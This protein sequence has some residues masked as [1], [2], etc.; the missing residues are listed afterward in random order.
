[1]DPSAGAAQDRPSLAALLADYGL[2]VLG[3][4]GT[5][6]AALAAY[7]TWAMDWP[8][9]FLGAAI[10][11]LVAYTLQAQ[12]TAGR[13]VPFDR[14]LLRSTARI[15]PYAGLI[16][17]ALSVPTGRPG[18]VAGFLLIAAGTYA[19]R[20]LVDSPAGSPDRGDQ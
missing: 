15:G 13:G 5:I 8:L 4:V 18:W 19:L 17:I 6:L 20:R 7:G 12:D 11:G 3:T 1:M 14:R 9:A 2:T 16:G 10:G